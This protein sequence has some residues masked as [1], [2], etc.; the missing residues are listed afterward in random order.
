MTK[1]IWISSR[2]LYIPLVLVIA[3]AVLTDRKAGHVIS[4]IPGSLLASTFS[5]LDFVLDD[6]EIVRDSD[7]GSLNMTILGSSDIVYVNLSANGN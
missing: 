1:G 2:F 4:Q 3:L 7:W 5:Q 6:R